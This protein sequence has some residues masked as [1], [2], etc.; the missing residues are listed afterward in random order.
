[1][2]LLRRFTLLVLGFLAG[3]TVWAGDLVIGH[4]SLRLGMPQAEALA[5]LGKEFDAKQVSVTEGKFLLWTRGPETHAQYSAGTVSFRDGKLYRA[6]KA[7]GVAGIK[8]RETIEG[9]FGVL[10]EIAGKERKSCSIKTETLRV[11]ARDRG[12]D[13]KLITIEIPPDRRVMVKTFEPH[14]SPDGQDFAAGPEVDEYLV[15]LSSPK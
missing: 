3:G 12:V 9:L 10:S 15:D 11:P 5:A 1:M 13:V 4:I 8:G 7:W 14:V 2:T 6:S